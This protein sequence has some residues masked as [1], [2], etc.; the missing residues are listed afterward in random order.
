MN[1]EIFYWVFEFFFEFLKVNV[2]FRISDM[3]RHKI[4]YHAQE[5]SG[6]FNEHLHRNSLNF[7]LKR[8]STKRKKKLK[9]FIWIL[10]DQKIHLKWKKDRLTGYSN[11][12][13]FALLYDFFNLFVNNFSALLLCKINF[14]YIFDTGDFFQ[15][16]VTS[17]AT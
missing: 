15:N 5:F 9:K 11:W 8:Y 13:F 12:T 4:L 2:I 16:F 10:K 3:F 17:R 7:F 1:L 14:L 6:Y